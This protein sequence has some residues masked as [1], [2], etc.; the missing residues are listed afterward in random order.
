MLRVCNG[1]IQASEP[2]I[3]LQKSRKEDKAKKD[4]D[5]ADPVNIA[6]EV[7]DSSDEEDD[8]MHTYHSS[9]PEACVGRRNAG[10]APVP[11]DVRFSK[12]LLWEKYPSRVF[13]KPL[14]LEMIAYDVSASINFIEF[15]CVITRQA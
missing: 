8:G 13:A 2:A 9:P 15:V 1:I 10:A 7:V 6:T 4:A 11:D 5:A 3:F 14:L 12:A